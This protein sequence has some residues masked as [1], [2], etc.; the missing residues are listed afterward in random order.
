MA[1]VNGVAS[2]GAMGPFGMMP[3]ANGGVLVPGLMGEVCR[4][5]LYGKCAKAPPEVCVLAHPPVQQLQAAMASSTSMAMGGLSNM[6]M[7]PSAAAMAAAQVPL[8]PGRPLS[9]FTIVAATLPLLDAA[10]RVAPRCAL[11]GKAAVHVALALGVRL[12]PGPSLCAVCLYLA[13]PAVSLAPGERRLVCLAARWHSPT[14]RCLQPP[15]RRGCASAQAQTLAVGAGLA[16][17]LRSIIAAQAFQAAQAQ[18]LKLQGD[19]KDDEVCCVHRHL[20]S[21]LYL[22]Q[23]AVAMQQMQYQQALVMQQAL[24]QQQVAARAATSKTAAEL[25]AQRAAEI[26]KKLGGSTGDG[27]KAKASP[28]RSRSRSPAS[29]RSRSRSRSKSR[30]PLRFRRERSRSPIRYRRRSRSPPRRRH[31]SR[32]W[33]RGDHRLSDRRDRERRDKERERERERDRERARELERERERERD[34]DREKQRVRDRGRERERERAR[35]K[36]REKQREREREREKELRERDG[37]RDQAGDN[38][39]DGDHKDPAKDATGDREEG[40]KLLPSS[41]LGDSR[42]LQAEKEARGQPEDS[43]ADAMAALELKAAG[44]SRGE[45]VSDSADKV[46]IRGPA[47]DAF[48]IGEQGAKRLSARVDKAEA[49]DKGGAGARQAVT[50]DSDLNGSVDQEK[51]VREERLRREVEEAMKRVKEADQGSGGVTKEQTVQEDVGRQLHTAEQQ[52]GQSVVA[53]SVGQA[54]AKRRTAEDLGAAEEQTALVAAVVEYGPQLPSA[55]EPQLADE[56]P[57][58]PS[59][60]K[61]GV[62][63]EDKD[64]RREKHRKHRRKHEIG[65]DSNDEGGKERHRKHRRKHHRHKQAEEE[66][67]EGGSGG[68]QDG[69]E[70]EEEGKKRKRKGER[71]SKGNKQQDGE[72]EGEED[73]P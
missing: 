49:G 9:L 37:D 25:A 45:A 72:V 40:V 17:V 23:Q 22:H 53:S 5:Y 30:T 13:L 62:D 58:E 26:S 68:E 21:I 39:R 32:S 10:M 71:R 52:A 14:P 42:P 35:D 2:Y 6:P 20:Q 55:D 47:A 43:R 65:E 69:E 67:E 57:K 31:R 12:S 56:T 36:D 50:K 8:R 1:A 48:G 11:R 33:D 46:S 73:L 41:P 51:K 61:A 28:R 24:A 44:R 29:S 16:V 19:K 64:K 15:K 38:D 63:D 7:G 27:G 34:R 66:T 59:V 3:G 70:A 54:P 60:L 18:Q 4:D